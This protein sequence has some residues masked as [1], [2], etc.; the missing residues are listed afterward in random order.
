MYDYECKSYVYMSLINCILYHMISR[1]CPIVPKGVECANVCTVSVLKD[2]THWGFYIC[3]NLG[4]L[5]LCT[6]P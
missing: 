3:I 5:S 6:E 4:I 2:I 1:S